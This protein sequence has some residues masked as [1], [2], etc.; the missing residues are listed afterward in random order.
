VGSRASPSNLQRWMYCNTTTRREGLCTIFWHYSYTCRTNQI[1]AVTWLQRVFSKRASLAGLHD[2]AS[3]MGWQKTS[4]SHAK[5]GPRDESNYYA[6]HSARKSPD[7]PLRVVVMQ[8]IQCCKSEGLACETNE[9]FTHLHSWT[10]TNKAHK[11]PSLQPT[12]LC[13][14]EAEDCYNRVNGVALGCNY[15][16]YQQREIRSTF[17]LT[18]C[19]IQHLY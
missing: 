12:A 6:F 15:K 1:A 3:L 19:T 4:Q 7:P 18:L 5:L 16:G 13:T 2:F 10:I 11:Y 17:I 8:Y 9:S 14:P